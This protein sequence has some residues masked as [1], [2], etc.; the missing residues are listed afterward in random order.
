MTQP[1]RKGTMRRFTFVILCLWSTSLCADDPPAFPP[2]GDYAIEKVEGWSVLVHPKLAKDKAPLV[3]AT[4]EQLR[5][6]LYEVRRLVPA[7]AVKKLQA[8]K[9]WVE[10]FHPLH[11]C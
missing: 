2:T 6:Q 4:L 10:D 9:I 5:H 11:A 1:Y 3:A 7:T 8:V